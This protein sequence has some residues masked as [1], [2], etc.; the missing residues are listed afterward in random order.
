[1]DLY[2]LEGLELIPDIDF[3]H[4]R[5]F[6]S[7]IPY[8][9]LIFNFSELNK[10]RRSFLPISLFFPYFLLGQTLCLV[11]TMVFAFVHLHLT[12]LG[13]PSK[14][15]T[16]NEIVLIYF[17]P[18]PPPPN[19]DIKSKKIWYPSWPHTHRW[20]FCQRNLFFL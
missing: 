15:C 6:I 7:N 18:F 13:K 20:I 4:L 10:K 16:N 8:F 19:K 9:I 5:S 12:T 11:R 1:M 3:E 17:D 2:L 14:K